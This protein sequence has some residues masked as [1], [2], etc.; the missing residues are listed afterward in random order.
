MAK[1]K[2]PVIDTL[3]E[4]IISASQLIARSR[5]RNIIE[6]TISADIGL[7]GGVPCGCTILFSGKPK[8]GK[9]TSVL[10]YAVNANRKFKSKIFYCNIEGRLDAKTLS[11]IQ[12]INTDEIKV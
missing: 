4:N 12:G 1:E 5:E 2:S 11:Q 7:G 3:A 10:Q 9:T 6:G 8:S